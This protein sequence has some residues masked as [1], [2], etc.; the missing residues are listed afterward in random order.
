MTRGA[1]IEDLVKYLAFLTLTTY[2][3]T[4]N[5]HKEFPAMVKKIL[6]LDI[7]ETVKKAIAAKEQKTEEAAPEKK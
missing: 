7:R 2:A 5:S 3:E 6:G 4:W 1:T